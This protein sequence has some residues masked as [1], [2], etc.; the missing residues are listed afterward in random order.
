MALVYNFNGILEQLQKF[1][2]QNVMTVRNIYAEQVYSQ[3]PINFDAVFYSLSLEKEEQQ[4]NNIPNN[5]PRT[6]IDSRKRKA[7]EEGNKTA[8][9]HFEPSKDSTAFVFEREEVHPL[10]ASST[11]ALAALL[12]SKDSAPSR[13]VLVQKSQVSTLLLTV[14]LP[15]VTNPVKLKLR[16]DTTADEL[17]RA[18]LLQYDTETKDDINKVSLPSNPKAYKLRIA[19]EDGTPDTDIPGTPTYPSF[20]FHAIFHPA[21]HFHAFFLLRCFILLSFCSS[22]PQPHSFPISFHAALKANRKVGQLGVVVFALC[23][24]KKFKEDPASEGSG[25][26]ANTPTLLKVYLPNESGFVS[27]VPK[28]D[29]TLRQ[30]REIVCA[31][32]SLNPDR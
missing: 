25:A 9:R 24:D 27:V 31:K 21:A 12:Q 29:M 1:R 15:G 6:Q 14:F 16:E 30:L 11:S 32:R 26:T 4:L 20:Q 17:I 2:E 8:V 19:E 13:S 5:N 7:E 10:P 18:S 22:V 23:R 3:S 28:E